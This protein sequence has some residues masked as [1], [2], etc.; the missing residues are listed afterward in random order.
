MS[1]QP[2]DL[3]VLFARLNQVGREQA[4]H[5]DALIQS[6][7]VTADEI[8]RQSDERGHGVVEVSTEE[9]GPEASGDRNEGSTSHGERRGRDRTEEERSTEAFRDPDLGQ[10]VDVSG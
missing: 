2:I 8:A 6:Q 1:V 10:N 5:R 4:L 9:E 7:A 3:Q